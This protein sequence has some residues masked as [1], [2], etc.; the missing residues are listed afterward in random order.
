MSPCLTARIPRNFRPAINR[1]VLS[2][3]HCQTMAA[4]L[5]WQVQCTMCCVQCGHK[6]CGSKLAND[7]SQFHSQVW[8]PIVSNTGVACSAPP[9]GRKLARPWRLMRLL[10]RMQHLRGKKWLCLSTWQWVANSGPTNRCQF[11]GAW[12]ILYGTR[13]VP[14]VP[15]QHHVV[16]VKQRLM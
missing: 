16:N 5:G 6:P 12:R 1:A 11:S 8:P 3:I 10:T 13:L 9:C 2:S 4:P 14:I 7:K 15:G